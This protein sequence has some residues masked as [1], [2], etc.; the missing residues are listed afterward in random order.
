MKSF[1]VVFVLAMWGFGGTAESGRY[2][3]R[4]CDQ[5]STVL[6][7]LARGDAVARNDQ[8][9]RCDGASL[10]VHR[11]GDGSEVRL[12]APL[13]D[14]ESV[15]G[16]LA[17]QRMSGSRDVQWHG[18]AHPAGMAHGMRALHDADV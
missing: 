7:R 10:G 11:A 15:L 14:D 9:H 5:H 8:A 16:N 1:S 6:R 12:D 13:D 17:P 18:P 4:G 2:V 3:R